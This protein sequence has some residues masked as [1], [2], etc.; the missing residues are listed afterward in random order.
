MKRREVTLC[1]EAPQDVRKEMR[2]KY[3]KLAAANEEKRRATSA[4]VAAVQAG[5]GK[6]RITDYLEGDAAAAKRD[7]HEGLALMFAACRIPEITINHPLFVNAM[8][9]V[10]RAGPGYVPPKRSFIGGAGLVAEAIDCGMERKTGGYVAGILQPVVEEV[11]PENVVAFSMDGGS[12]YA[13]A[14]QELIAKWPHIQQ[15]PCATH[16]MDLLQE[17]VGKMGWAKGVVDRTGEMISFVHNHHWTR[18]YLR[19]P[20]LVEGKVLQPLKPAGT[21]FGTQ[22]IA[23][24]R[25][26]ELRSTLNAMV[27]TDRWEEWAVGSRKEAAETFAARV[28]D[29]AWWRTAEFFCKLLTEDVN[30]LLDEDEQQLSSTDK[31]QIRRIIKNRWDNNLACAMHV[32]GRILNP[33]NQE[34]DIFGSDANFRFSRHLSTSTWRSFG[35]PKALARRAKV[36]AGKYSMVKWWQWNG[37]DAPHLMSLAV[38]VLS[39]L[40]AASP[41]ERGWGTWDAVHTA[42]QNRLGSAKCQNLV[43]VA[44]NWN[45]PPIPE[46]YNRLDETEVEEEEGKD[47]VLEDEYA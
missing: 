11:G 5:G 6:R 15:D 31:V 24:S 34:E 4:A 27:L 18:A 42:R 44:H 45:V 26:C 23:V 19:T 43:F 47:D 35:M 25:L 2:T 41:C 38:R 39:Q 30:N 21:R 12:N 17:D 9:L 3:E 37:T 10:N 13:V 29:A 7:A 14:V 22:Y 33:A 40:V 36:K 46:G 28:L 16:V 1:K 32:A 20:E 8:L